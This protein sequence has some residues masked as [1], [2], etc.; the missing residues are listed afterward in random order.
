M[1]NLYPPVSRLFQTNQPI[2]L[3]LNQPISLKDV[4]A[5]SL[6]PSP[7]STSCASLVPRP[8]CME[9]LGTRLQSCKFLNRRSFATITW[10]ALL[11]YSS[12]PTFILC[13]WNACVCSSG[14]H[15]VLLHSVHIVS[16]CMYLANYSISVI[17][18]CL[19]E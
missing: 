1:P 2:R 18:L 17:R 11:P 8:T 16:R 7:L 6:I 10:M 9:G 14:V 12:Q 15:S 13:F 19:D 5:C 4:P 3:A